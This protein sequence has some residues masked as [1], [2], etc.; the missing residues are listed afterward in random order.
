VVKGLYILNRF[1]FE[2]IY[3]PQ[4]RKEIATLVDIYAPV[5]T[6]ETIREELHLLHDAEV[7]LTGWGGA[8][9]DEEF[10]AAAPNLKAVFYGAGTIKPV[11]TDALWDRGIIITS[12]YAANAVPV[13]EFTISQILF[14]L[15]HGWQ[16][17]FQIKRE[18]KWP[19]RHPVPGAY[20]STIGIISLG[21]TGRKVLELLRCYDMHVIVYSTSLTRER[22]EKLGVELCSLDE[23]FKRADV[24]SLHTAA[25]PATK[26]MITG[27]H[28][29]SMK[30]GAA[31]I[32]TAR[33]I[34]VQENEMIEVLERRPDLLAVLD[35]TY[36]EPP[37]Q[38]SPLYTLPNVILTPHIAGS[39]DK[40]CQRMGDYAVEELKRYCAGQPLKWRIT[41]ESAASLA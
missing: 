30:R 34:V 4:Q 40:E 22:A 38:D 9:M 1:G 21:M 25:L 5:Q 7:I 37:A 29:A 17:V 20:G 36:P 18:R 28:F 23:I 13:A 3:G 26:G 10:L 15:K 8:C 41:K 19:E 39:M 33:G 6:R 12:S 16:Y 11:V 2:R 31:F 35:V 27:R 32:N 24:V 14:C